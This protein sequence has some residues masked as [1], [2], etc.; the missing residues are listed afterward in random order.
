VK[1]HELERKEWGR[2]G[3]SQV[4]VEREPRGFHRPSLLLRQRTNNSRSLPSA[5]RGRSHTVSPLKWRDQT[6][7]TPEG[8]AGDVSAD[9]HFI[10]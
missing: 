10:E 6:D 2:A 1:V 8:R 7:E 4:V 3:F 9:S 5:V